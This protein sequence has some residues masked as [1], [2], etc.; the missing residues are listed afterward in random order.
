MNAGR[1]EPDLI[2][3]LAGADILQS[4]K[5]GNRVYYKA[6]TSSPGV[7]ERQSLLI[8]TACQVDALSADRRFATAYG[9][10][11]KILLKKNCIVCAFTRGS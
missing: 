11:T 9:A 1:L 10:P 6:K 8:K 2:S 4:R 3:Q 7:H 5:E